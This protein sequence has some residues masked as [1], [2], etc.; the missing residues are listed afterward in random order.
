MRLG[1]GLDTLMTGAGGG[2]FPVTST[3]TAAVFGDS[4]SFANVITSGGTQRTHEG[5][6]YLTN[7][8]MLA[9]Q[10]MN[11]QEVNNKGVSGN[12]TTQMAARL[13]DL[14]G[15][16]FDVCFVMGGTND[17]TS[18]VAASTIITNLG[19]VYDYVCGTLGK[20][21]V[22]LPILPRDYWPSFTAGEITT[23]LATIATVNAWI[24]AQ[25]GRYAGKLIANT[26][27]VHDDMDDGAGGAI[28]ESTYDDL[29]PAMYGGMLNGMALKA[30]LAPYFGNNPEPDFSAAANLLLNGT[31]S[32][33]GGTAGSGTTGTV[34]TSFS[35]THSGGTGNTVLSKDTDGKQLI[36]HSTF[37]GT[38]TDNS[39]LS[40]TITQ[41][42][43][44][45]DVGDTL[46]ARVLVEVLGTPTPV[47]MVQVALQCRL[48]GTN[49]PTLVN[50]FGNDRRQSPNWIGE[51]YGLRPGKYLI[52]TPDLPVTQGSGLSCEWRFE[53]L[54]DSATNN[55]ATA[56]AKVY[57]GGLYKR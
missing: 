9:N 6:G 14:D 48:T 13:S 42:S 2:G 33:T 56:T 38:T 43:G 1:L 39:R 16:T 57:G 26:S 37:N 46:Y 10:R 35:A 45:F 53:I 5:V 28:T 22:A 47:R 29:H 3:L 52:E 41:A 30:I 40:Q 24:Y 11:F 34:A 51:V 36:A 20:R 49:P 25:H 12:S 4:I 17:V 15:I 27:R 31:M 8:N 7:Y 23:G 19:A 54:G 44:K 32:G 21:C 55:T 50:C 18:K